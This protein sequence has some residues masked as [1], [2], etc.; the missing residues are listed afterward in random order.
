MLPPR[1][2]SR[3][4]HWDY[5]PRRGDLPAHASMQHDGKKVPV[6]NLAVPGGGP[7][8][9]IDLAQDPYFLANKLFF[10]QVRCTLTYRSMT[11]DSHAVG[12]TPHL[13]IHGLEIRE[14]AGAGRGVFATRVV[15]PQTIVEIS[16]VLL[17]DPDE[18]QR[19]GRQT[20]LDSYT[21]VW[22]KRSDG[23]TMALALGLGA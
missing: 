6:A 13:N 19:H 7:R 1:H 3:R 16:P 20:L 17:F 4:P 14:T 23:S 8:A 10:S 21:F 11:D 22:D 12:M 2:S 5:Q 18:Y 15:E 9:L